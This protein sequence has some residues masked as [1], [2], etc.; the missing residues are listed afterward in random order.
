[1][2]VKLFKYILLIILVAILSI[3]VGELVL[4]GVAVFL[5]GVRY[6]ATAGVEEK[7]SAYD[8]LENF[9][10]YQRHLTPHNNWQNYYTNAFGF[11]DTEFVEKKADGVFRI[12]SMGDSFCFSLLPYPA[13]VLTLVESHLEDKLGNVKVELYNFGISSTGVSD[14]GKLF[15][16]IKD[17]YAPDLALLH[18]YIGNDGPDFYR[19]SPDISPWRYSYLLHYL[20]NTFILFKSVKRSVN[21]NKKLLTKIL[22]EGYLQKIGGGLVDPKGP[23]HR[24]HPER[25]L[26]PT[27]NEEAYIRLMARELGRLYDHPEENIDI[28]F[29]PALEE[30][31]RIR[32]L[33]ENS[34][35]LLVLV[36]Y[37]SQL[38]IYP[39]MREKIIRKIKKS[40]DYHDLDPVHIDVK[41]PNRILEQYSSRNGLLF[42][43]ITDELAQSATTNP[44]LYI[45]SDTHWN[46]QGN[47]IAAEIEAEA[48]SRLIGNLSN[49]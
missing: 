18:F 34:G 40:P 14:H 11:N 9:I 7:L 41:L 49:E 45:R 6:M 3:T 13:N 17:R 25:Y 22:Q 30:I 39:E 47:S 4:R 27:F 28:M 26:G 24:D 16:L 42:L 38:Q 44:Y 23:T 37:P 36:V 20:N 29:A 35:V 46:I 12:V 19:N 8:T 32:I 43:D 2:K 21:N 5:P 48:L 33:A 1:M 31:D 10:K 15:R